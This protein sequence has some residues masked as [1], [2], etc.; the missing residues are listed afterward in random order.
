MSGSLRRYWEDRKQTERVMRRD[1]DGTLWM[2]SGDE[3]VMDEEGYLKG[4]FRVLF[5]A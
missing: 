4:N 1:A 2:H 5:S 3:G